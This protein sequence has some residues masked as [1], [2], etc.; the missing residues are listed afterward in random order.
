[1]ARQLLAE[2]YQALIT[3]VESDYKSASQFFGREAIH[4]LRVGIKRI[5]AFLGL[6]GSIDTGFDQA[7]ILANLGRLFKRAGKLRHF[8]I[9]LDL[10]KRY[11]EDLGLKL[12]WYFNTLKE[13]EL[14]NRK[15]FDHFCRDF[16]P[17]A[18]DRSVKSIVKAT[19]LLN[20][21]STNAAIIQHFEKLLTRLRGIDLH[22]SPDSTDFHSIRILAKE[23]RYV[24]EIVRSCVKA[25]PKIDLLDGQLRGL[26][27]ALGVWHDMEVS[28]IDIQKL[29][30][31]EVAD[32]AL[33]TDSITRLTAAL[34]TERDLQLELFRAR[35]IDFQDA[36]RLAAEIG[37]PASSHE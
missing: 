8:Q 21:K 2:Y 14:I 20:R 7:A 34:A 35:W 25:D 1:M 18:L 23:T 13:Q 22:D 28:I 33:C 19:A 12:D 32:P 31:P 15:K 36:Q 27:Q 11:M 17:R 3:K 4:E 26:H 6:V 30:G 24:L 10:T 9:Q 16:S 5:R 37:E 29:C